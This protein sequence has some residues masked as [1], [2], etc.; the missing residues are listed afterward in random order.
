M[1]NPSPQTVSVSSP[2]VHL[3]QVQPLPEATLSDGQ[4][5][6]ISL[7]TFVNSPVAAVHGLEVNNLQDS[8]S[9]GLFRCPIGEFLVNSGMPDPLRNIHLLSSNPTNVL[10][11]Q[12][13]NKPY[14]VNK[15]NLVMLLLKN[16]DAQQEQHSLFK[17]INDLKKSF[18]TALEFYD[19]NPSCFKAYLS[20][21]YEG[22][23]SLF[24]V[25]C[26]IPETFY[27][28]FRESCCPSRVSPGPPYA[29]DLSRR[30]A[31]RISASGVDTVG[32]GSVGGLCLSQG[33]SQNVG[34]LAGSGV[35]LIGGAFLAVITGIGHG[36]DYTYRHDAHIKVLD[37]FHQ[38]VAPKLLEQSPDNPDIWRVSADKTVMEK[39]AFSCTELYEKMEESKLLHL[40]VN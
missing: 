26:V 16:S 15:S 24:D 9:P 34:C 6:A 4:N 23:C 20:D 14:L 10:Q 12:L 39:V 5:V 3:V 7:F 32:L 30:D 38:T 28:L 35:G 11:I 22:G 13:G 40:N 21:A 27:E 8:Q 37:K 33:I 19:V 18:M 29:R 36:V 25:C 2:Q 31:M 1:S 17:E